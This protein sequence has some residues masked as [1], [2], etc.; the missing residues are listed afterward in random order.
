MTRHLRRS[1]FALCTSIFLSL[2][3]I[4]QTVVTD[5]DVTRQAENTPPTDNWVLYTRA[6]TPPTA[7][8]FVNGPGNPPLG[9]GSLQ[10]T[11]VTGGEK[12]FLFNYDHV[13]EKLSEINSI[14]Y[15]TYRTAGNAQQ[16]AALN[17]QIDKNGGTLQ[18]GDFATL[19]FE[20]VYNTSQGAVV[21]G[22]WQQWIA[23][24]SGIWWSTQ[25]INGQCAGATST[26]DKTW[27][28]IVTNNPDATI[29][30]VGINQGSGNPGLVSSVD[31][32]T[33]DDVIY[34][35][36]PSADSD[37][38]GQ[39]DNCDTDD[40]GDGIPD[41]ND[42]CPTIANPD[43]TDTDSDGQGNACDTDDDNDG[44]ADGSDNCP[45]VANIN[46]A[47]NDNDALGDACDADDD[48]DG[49]P[50]ANDNCPL[51]PNANQ[52]D[53]DGDGQGNS[54][55]NDDDGDG[56]IDAEDCDPLDKKNDK[57]LIC[58]KG[59][60][61]CVAQNA[62]NAHLKHGDV[63]GPCSS[64]VAARTIKPAESVIINPEQFSLLGSPNP[65]RGMIKLQYTIPAD[66]RVNIKVYDL[67][68]KEV[69]SL[70]SGNR[71]TGTYNIEYNT[72]KLNTGVYYCRMIAT[73]EGKDHIETM[74]F[75]KVE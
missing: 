11:T 15:W 57:V 47:N 37:G 42:N 52:L 64:T 2:S 41:A 40:D 56:V 60:T 59:Q 45:L 26:C 34:N 39:G 3:G 65:A 72:E 1:S 53:T 33:F 30:A 43:Q 48:N 46:Q 4:G 36:E 18:P 9:C 12:V 25:P 50:D 8:V 70:Y 73:A 54:C 58:H 28:E 21:S 51:A 35:F 19:V 14:S 22:Q 74:K 68:G 49:V 5:A 16:V 62:V 55:D 10:L 63:V 13:G 75:I 24:G 71:T 23:T 6:G 66:S 27:A 61:L 32:F 20:P 44:V 69:G 31:A 29:L 67:M 17:V 7:G 38:D